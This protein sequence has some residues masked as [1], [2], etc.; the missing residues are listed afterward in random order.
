[1]L[2]FKHGAYYRTVAKSGHR[3][4]HG[5]RVRYARIGLVKSAPLPICKIQAP[6]VL[7][8]LAL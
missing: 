8:S 5:S 6:L 3:A 1:M 7:A 4:A 2:G